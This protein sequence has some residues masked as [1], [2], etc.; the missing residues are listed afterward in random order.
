MPNRYQST[1]KKAIFDLLC[2][3]EGA[4]CLACFAEG[5]GRRGHNMGVKLQIDHCG[6]EI[7]LLCQKHNTE[8]RPLS[9]EAREPVMSG[10]SAMNVCE[11]MK[12]GELIKGVR[13][14]VDY[15]QG[16]VEMHA[17][18]IILDNWL[19]YINRELI[20]NGFLSKDDAIW[21]GAYISG[22]NASTITRYYRTYSA[23]DGIYQQTKQDNTSGLMFK[24]LEKQQEI[25]EALKKSNNFSSNGHSGN[26]HKQL[27]AT[28][29]EA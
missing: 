26:G 6:R 20:D 8:F 1:A 10:Y 3:Y 17:S 18:Q 14:I 12:K 25:M 2:K 23:R 19:N 15:N 21:N 4:Y 29:K 13:E 27:L 9:V 22:G 7:H 5:N 28:V 24:S 11:R 16:S